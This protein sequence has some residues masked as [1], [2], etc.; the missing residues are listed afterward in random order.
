MKAAVYTRYGPPEVVEIVDVPKPVPK[1]DEVLIKVRA[2]TVSSADWRA[3]SLDIPRGFGLMA[4]LFFGVGKPR[5]PVLGTELSGDIEA[6]GK[7]VRNFKAGDEVF[8][9]SGAGLGCHA[10][11]KCMP[12]SGMVVKKPS[13]LSYEEAAAVSFG[14]TTAL[15]YLRRGKIARGERV[16]VNGASGAVGTAVIQIAKHF[17]GEVTGV[18]STSNLEL[19]KS[20]GADNVIDYTN[21]DF[22]R[23][24][25]AY[26]IIVD[27]AGTAPFSRSKG[28]LKDG[29]RL[30]L[31]LATLPDTLQGLWVSMTGKAKVVA[32][33]AGER[34]EDLRFLATLAESAELKPV[35]GR[36]YPFE[37]IVEA[38]RLVD[39]GHKRGSVVLTF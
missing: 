17:G 26:D 19:V 7:D 38:H 22:T 2:T 28:S 14:G 25:V 6:V 13:N 33:P 4:R 35:I 15:D 1:H 29:G 31:V 23:N 30:L 36:R 24:G 12:E 16:L 10:E 34:P 39:T 8:A 11:Y 27:V 32:G 21:E 5:Q 20:I 37:E 3:R 18:C 9:F